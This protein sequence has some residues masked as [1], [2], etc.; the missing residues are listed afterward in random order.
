MDAG[1]EAA[2][3]RAE[4]AE[5]LLRAVLEAACLRDGASL[6]SSAEPG[7]PAR[8]YE[9]A[10]RLGIG[11]AFGIGG[12]V[13]EPGAMVRFE[14]N[15]YRANTQVAPYPH[16]LAELVSALRYRRH[17]GWEVELAD[18]L[19]RDKPGRH[20]GESRGLTLVVT[21]EGPNSYD[22]AKVMR[23]AHYFIVPAATYNRASWMRWL[24]DQLG[25]VDEHERM[26]DFAFAAEQNIAPGGA[27]DEVLERPYRP[28]HGPGWDPYLI[29]V[30]GTEEDRRTSFRGELSPG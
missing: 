16:E 13:N 14:P 22:H 15:P 19:Q 3:A 1:T 30:L 5:S 12:H 18:D 6:E 4:A 21:R 17:L 24:F 7:E 29:T 11:H 8:N 23:V 20:S 27:T 2:E 28:N 26:E 9:L 10:L 25:K